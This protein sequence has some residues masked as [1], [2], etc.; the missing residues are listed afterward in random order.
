MKVLTQRT[1]VRARA[2]LRLGFGGGGTDVS[3]YSDEFGGAVLNAT[4]NQFAYCTIEEITTPAL[5]IASDRQERAKAAADGVFA[6][7]G[8]LAL[9]K[10]VYARVCRQFNDGKPLSIQVTTYADI[11]AGSGLGTSSTLVVAMLSAFDEYLGLGLGEYDLAHLAFDIERNDCK[12]S[13]GKQDQYAA[14][15]GGFNFM[16]FG[17]TRLTAEGNVIVN[18]LRVKDWVQRE[19]EASLVLLH[20]GQSR[21]SARIIDE[22]VANVKTKAAQSIDAMHQLKHDAITMKEA[23][24]TGQLAQFGKLLGHSWEAKKRMASS[25]SNASIDRLMTAAMNAGAYAGKVSGAGGGGVV[26]LMAEPTQRMQLLR[27]VE[28]QDAGF[29]CTLIPFEFTEHGAVSWRA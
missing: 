13:G 8:V 19:L 7:D 3:P 11:S 14:A 23:L 1:R 2:P 26:M 18:P 10:G 28:G 21:E 22:Q 4:I 17:V 27:A 25:I 6:D 29:G 12:L 24:L 15:F 16:E 9:H 5:L 20:T